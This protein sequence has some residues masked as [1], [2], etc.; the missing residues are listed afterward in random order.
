M[1]VLLDTVTFLDAAFSSKDLSK[2]AKDLLLH[3]D[4]ELYVSVASCWEIAIK[5][6]IGRLALPEDP[7]KFVPILEEAG[8]RYATA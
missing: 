8:C 4:S 6:S 1:K 2:R 5:Y 7:H 3:A